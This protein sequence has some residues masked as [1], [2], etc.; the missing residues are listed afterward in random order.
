M[1]V[2]ESWKN[3]FQQQYEDAKARG[4]DATG[5]I[6]V[7]A[8]PTYYTWPTKEITLWGNV[9]WENYSGTG[10]YYWVFGDG[11][12]SD[13]VNITDPRYLSTTH[14]YSTM[15]TYYATLIVDDDLGQ[16]AS[17]TT[18]ILVMDMNDAKV[19]KAIE[20]GLRYLYTQQYAD[21]HWYGSYSYSPAPE[22]AATSLAILSMEENGHLP[23]LSPD[24]DIYKEVVQKGFEWLWEEIERNS[25]S[26]QSA[27]NPDTDGNGYGYHFSNDRSSYSDPMALA[28]IIASNSPESVIENGP[29]W[30]QGQTYYNVAQNIVDEIAWS[31]TESG[32]YRG[33]WRYKITTS[34]YGNSDMSTTQWTVLSL[35]YAENWGISAPSWVRTE[36]EYWI[37]YIQRS[38]GGFGYTDPSSTGNLARVGSGFT[39]L[40][41]MG[42]GPG[43]SRYDNAINWVENNFTTNDGYS[44]I[45]GIYAMYKGLW[46]YDL[47]NTIIGTHNWYSEFTDYLLTNQSSQG[48]WSGSWASDAL[49]TGF[50]IL[51]LTPRVII[52]NDSLAVDIRNISYSDFPDITLYIDVYSFGE[53]L[54]GLSS[55]DFIV[56]E[57]GVMQNISINYEFGQYL[58]SYTSTNPY[59]SSND[60]IVIA[61][62]STTVNGDELFD[63]DDITYTYQTVPI[64]K[65]TAETIALSNTIQDSG[66]CI[67]I[68]ANI[69]DDV[70]PYVNSATLYYRTTNTGATF[71][72]V[73][74]Y[75]ISGDLWRGT[76]YH[77][78]VQSP[79]V[80]YYIYACPASL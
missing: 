24:D 3:Y 54:Q 4:I 59:P 33:G 56:T 68:E 19:N 78:A 5:D 60:R 8:M 38:D 58:V 20:D 41:Y 9:S 11:T 18:R 35:L 49:N 14:T 74:M 64:I 55:S 76:I 34:N 53:P 15:A 75:N 10:T 80:D 31:Q 23:W 45:Y 37:S 61:E 69:I 2:E 46:F 50:G 72:E 52:P 39:C 67:Q 43:D 26:T 17:A 28:A 6:T 62:V 73:Q 29:T 66:R 47:L 77:N 13:T 70:S 44:G 40:Y 42:D 63:F 22:V 32:N 65:R 7:K 27:G 71:T 30:V 48:T 21:G 79:G 16:T 25:I 12:Q 57:D 36:M 1:S 51:V